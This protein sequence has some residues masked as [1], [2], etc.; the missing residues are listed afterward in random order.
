[1]PDLTPLAQGVFAWLQEP[2]GLGVPNAGVVLDGDG[3]TVI[4][5]LTV[6]SQ[7]GPFGD[8]VDALGF[9]VRRV[10]LTGD[11]LDFVG[12]TVRFR[13]AGVYGT[14]AASA[15]LDQ[16]PN[17]AVLRRLHPDLADEI[18]DEIR[19]RSVTHVVAEATQLTPAAFAIPLRGQAAENLV[20]LVPESDVLFA[21]ALCC[22][23]VTP[24]AFDGD[25]AAWADTLDELADL[26]TTI[27]PGHGPVGGA[28]EV[29]AL[30]GYLRA[31]VDAG[32]DPA[33]I[34]PGPWDDWVGR[35][36]DVVNVERAAGLAAG[37][38]APP[39]S[40]LRAVGLR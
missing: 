29:R 24:L 5:T 16:P 33:R 14:R 13:H 7:F 4:D 26:A 30:Q 34:G 15:H 6:P 40:L 1:M 25:P 8:A 32:G 17:P 27:V 39:P 22:F 18:D 11:H 10:V 31:C 36:W 37:D 9:P 21:G 12:G 2:A 20:V 23:G 38:L 19:T 3:A 35:E 28:D